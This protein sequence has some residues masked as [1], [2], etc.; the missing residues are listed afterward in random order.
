M[1]KYVNSEGKRGKRKTYTEAEKT[2][3]YH[4]RDVD[5]GVLEPLSERRALGHRVR[6]ADVAVTV[7]VAV[8][9]AAVLSAAPEGLLLGGVAIGVARGR[10]CR[11][12]ARLSVEDA[13]LCGMVWYD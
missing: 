1:G 4:C 13:H 10:C 6:L 8:L 11:V 3:C 9:G 12:G 7:A 5:P 2:H